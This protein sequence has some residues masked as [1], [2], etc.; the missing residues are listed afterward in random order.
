MGIVDHAQNYSHILTQPYSRGIDTIDRGL[1]GN[2]F[3]M[4]TRFNFVPHR[5]IHKKHGPIVDG[6]GEGFRR[7]VH[8]TTLIPSS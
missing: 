8:I 1:S 3:V 5:R 2:N 6:E 7:L 4:P